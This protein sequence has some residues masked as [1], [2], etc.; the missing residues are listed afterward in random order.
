MREL[1]WGE[2]EVMSIQFQVDLMCNVDH[3]LHNRFC[4][5]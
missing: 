5:L 2:M 1:L 3:I 4:S